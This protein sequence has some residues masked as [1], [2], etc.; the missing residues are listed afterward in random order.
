M[1]ALISSFAF[2]RDFDDWSGIFVH[3]QAEALRSAGVDARVVT[4]LPVAIRW[5]NSIHR[6][7]D[8]WRFYAQRASVKWDDFKGVPVFR[9][10]FLTPAPRFWNKWA[11]IFYEQGLSRSIWELKPAFDFDIFHAHSALFDGSAGAKLKY[12]FGTPI[13]L[14]EHTGPFAAITNKPWKKERARLALTTADRLI[15]ISEKQRA[16]IS[17]E[18]RELNADK[19]VAIGNGYDPRIFFPGPSLP[20]SNAN[21]RALWVGGLLPVKQLVMLV[22]AFE[23]ALRLEARLR[24]TLVGE[25]MLTDAIKYYIL[26]KGLSQKITMLPRATRTDVGAHMRSHDFLVMSSKTESFGLVVLEAMA[27]GLPVLTTRCGGPEETV[28]SSR[29]GEIVDNNL[30]S[31]SQGFLRICGRLSEFDR[32]E[33]SAFAEERFGYATIAR[34]VIEVYDEFCGE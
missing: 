10:P 9:F 1:K 23:L 33:I 32:Q 7:K 28:E 22:D 2:P 11:P 34:Q 21:I 15:A 14:T 8:L 12:R 5:G 31:L 18:F 16:D 30:A 17:A 3:E 27:C 24:L 6:M 4:G 20:I 29:H 25:G 19:F 13:I 26:E